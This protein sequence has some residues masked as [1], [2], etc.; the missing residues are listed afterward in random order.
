MLP[1]LFNTATC[2]SVKKKNISHLTRSENHREVFLLR[3]GCQ[4]YLKHAR[5]PLDKP[6]FSSFSEVIISLTGSAGVYEHQAAEVFPVCCCL[7]VLCRPFSSWCLCKIPIATLNMLQ[8]ECFVQHIRGRGGER[9]LTLGKAC[10]S[11]TL[12]NKMVW[13]GVFTLAL[14]EHKKVVSR[15]RW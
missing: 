14:V 12:L 10:R 8:K 15:E 9:E 7:C 1:Q 13:P 3:P 4:L 11:D 6:M 5:R 2:W